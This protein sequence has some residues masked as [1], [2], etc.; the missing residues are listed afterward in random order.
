MNSDKLAS[1]PMASIKTP[2]ASLRT[3]PVTPNRLAVLKTNGLNPTPWTVPFMEI[4]THGYF[5]S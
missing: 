1:M 2:E 3:Q 5:M 4:R